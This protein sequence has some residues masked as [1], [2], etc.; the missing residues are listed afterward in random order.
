MIAY[1]SMHGSTRAVVDHLVGKL[2]E[3]GVAVKPFNLT[4]ADI[5]EL[6]MALVEAAGIVIATPM[7]LAGPH[8]SALYA[9][10]LIGALRPKMRFTAVIG[11]YGWGGR[12]AEAIKKMLTNLKVEMLEPVIVKG[13][14][15]RI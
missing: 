12:A 11:S 1:V 15:R 4:V 9:A 5:G 13:Y 8:P 7:V 3:R 6:A 14:P 2:L 10:Y